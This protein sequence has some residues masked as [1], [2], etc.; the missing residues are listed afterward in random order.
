MGSIGQS[1]QQRAEQAAEDRAGS[2]GQSGQQRAERAAE[3]RPGSRGQSGQQMVE[4]SLPKLEIY[5]SKLALML[6]QSAMTPI[7]S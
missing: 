7:S 1:G 4:Q 2:R 3:G 5:G 6:K